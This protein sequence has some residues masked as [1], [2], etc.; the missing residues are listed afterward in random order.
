MSKSLQEILDEQVA[1]H[2]VPGVSVG[3]VNGDE[4]TYATHGVTSVD[5]PLEVTQDTLFQF[6]S[7]GKTFTGTLIL[8]L[9]D[10]GKLS[11]WW[12]WTVTRIFRK[13]CSRCR[14]WAEG[15]IRSSRPWSRS[16]PTWC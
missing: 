12:V 5:N 10:Q 4:V 3:V 6:G 11:F 8:I 1:L 7:T 13:R 16:G 15:S 9:A 2:P 14:R